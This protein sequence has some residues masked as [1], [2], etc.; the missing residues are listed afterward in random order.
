MTTR[1]VKRRRRG[2]EAPPPIQQDVLMTATSF[3]SVELL[4]VQRS[5]GSRNA[6]THTHT[7]SYPGSHRPPSCPAELPVYAKDN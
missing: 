1:A 7:E 6:T 2:G 5:A 3:H 4:T